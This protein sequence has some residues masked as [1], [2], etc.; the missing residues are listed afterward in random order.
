MYPEQFTEYVNVGAGG[1][2]AAFA[3]KD[4]QVP[5]IIMYTSI[6]IDKEIICFRKCINIII[7]KV[8]IK[9]F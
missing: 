8:S 6:R 2:A 9:S 1:G 3:Y 4:D 7:N 5:I